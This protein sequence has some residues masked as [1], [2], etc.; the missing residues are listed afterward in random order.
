MDVKVD[1]QNVEACHWLK[2]NNSSKK[3]V[4]KLT[5]RKDADKTREAKVKMVKV[6]IDG[7]Q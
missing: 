2:S 7:H 3:L 1:P 4:I 5:K 6:R